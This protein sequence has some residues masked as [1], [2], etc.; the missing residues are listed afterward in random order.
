VTPLFRKKA[1]WDVGGIKNEACDIGGKGGHNRS[2][3]KTDK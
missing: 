3:G 2:Y 1:F